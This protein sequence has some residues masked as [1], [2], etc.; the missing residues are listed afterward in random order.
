MYSDHFLYLFVVI[1]CPTPTEPS[2]GFVYSPCE[3]YFDS[4][5]IVGC[6]S[7]YYINGT[8]KITCDANGAW[9]SRNSNCRGTFVTA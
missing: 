7:G 3:T 5:C 1:Y 4:Q 8:N 2:N 9:K 6:S